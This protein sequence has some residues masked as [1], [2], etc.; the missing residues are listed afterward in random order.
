M[1]RKPRAIEQGTGHLLAVGDSWFNYFPPFDALVALQRKYGYTCIRWPCPRPS[2][3]N[4]RH[5]YLQLPTAHTSS[6]SCSAQRK[7]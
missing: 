6:A 5:P 3:L 4:W 1:R 7:P 2:W